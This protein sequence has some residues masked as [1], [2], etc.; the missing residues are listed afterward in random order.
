MEASTQ[1]AGH[2][3][4]IASLVEH[5]RMRLRWRHVLAIALANKLARIAWSARGRGF[6]TSVIT[7]ATAQTA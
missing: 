2:S 1:F 5:Y 6:E 3:G 7:N 4:D